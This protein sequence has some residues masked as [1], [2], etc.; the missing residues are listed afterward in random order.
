M[1][2]LIRKGCD[3]SIKDQNGHTP[4]QCVENYFRKNKTGFKF[5]QEFKKCETID[6]IQNM[7]DFTEI[8]EKWQCNWIFFSEVIKFF[9]KKQA[10]KFSVFFFY[11]ISALIFLSNIIYSL[12]SPQEIS[13]Q[14][15]T[16]IFL[17]FFGL[18]QALFFVWISLNPGV[19]PK[20]DI[21]D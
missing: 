3:L 4:S 14:I 11:F 7:R 10:W 20:K 2:L 1:K 16:F 9:Y 19:V 18:S 15:S 12:I 17:T 5:I 13:I 6:M 8:K 21:N